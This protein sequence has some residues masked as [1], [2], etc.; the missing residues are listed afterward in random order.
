MNGTPTP[1]CLVKEML[2]IAGVHAD[3]VVY[4][5]GC[6]DG[7][8]VIAAA[9]MGAAYAIGV[10]RDPENIVEAENNARAAGVEDKVKFVHADLHE[11]D[12]SGATVVTLYLLPSIN[13]NLRPKLLECL[14]PGAR[15]VSHSFDM[16]DWKPEKVERLN[17]R[18]LYLWVVPDGQCPTISTDSGF[19]R[20]DFTCEDLAE[21]R[22]VL[23]PYRTGASD[24]ADHFQLSA[25]LANRSDRAV[26]AAAIE[27]GF[28][29]A[30]GQRT[31]ALR[32]T[33]SFANDLLLPSGAGL[34]SL[35]LASSETDGLLPG[36][37]HLLIDTTPFCAGRLRDELW[38]RA[39]LRLD[40]AFFVDGEFVGPNRSGIW[41][42]VS[43][44]RE[45]M[46]EIAKMVSCARSE[47]LTASRILGG[48]ERYLKR[49]AASE[50][51]EAQD[52]D[53]FARQRKQVSEI[54]SRARKGHDDEPLV[55]ALAAW[56]ARN[57]PI[58][59]R[60]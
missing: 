21:Y 12:I 39:M 5:L 4:D 26:A 25:V 44:R 37:Q 27:W 34:S 56:A 33:V 38:Q 31:S 23:I 35:P 30:S 53:L 58:L 11:T 45:V 48:I 42:S 1:F 9:Q 49:D 2:K 17:G 46:F 52:R 43:C 54:F 50:S 19:R 40:G 47:G 15:V 32:S 6:G 57:P 55:D 14:K 29:D 20:I 41:E 8:I 59:R 28:A 3:D 22:L 51:G 7:R 10:D 24:L 13:V 18:S 16:G 36:A 60:G